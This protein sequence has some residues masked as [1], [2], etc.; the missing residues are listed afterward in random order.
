VNPDQNDERDRVIRT[1]M[2]SAAFVVAGLQT[3]GLDSRSKHHQND[4]QGPVSFQLNPRSHMQNRHVEH[5]VRK[6]KVLT[7]HGARLTWVLIA[8][9]RSLVASLPF[10][11]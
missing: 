5:P 6:F 4:A 8:G 2:G 11:L 3:R 1:A 9:R 10:S 7:E